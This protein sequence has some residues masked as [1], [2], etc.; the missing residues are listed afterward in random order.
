MA[1]ATTPTPDATVDINAA[2]AATDSKPTN[3]AP[4]GAVANPKAAE[5]PATAPAPALILS[6]H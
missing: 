3:P 1:F 4:V 6:A 2:P 5:T